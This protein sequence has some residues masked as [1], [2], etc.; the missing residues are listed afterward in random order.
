MKEWT[1]D[2]CGRPLKKKNRMHGYT[3]C[4]KHMHQLYNHG[5]FLDDNPRTTKDL[6]D[7][8]VVDGETVRMHLYN[9]RCERVASTL[10]DLDM[11]EDLKYKKWRLSHRHVVTGSGAG[12]IREMSHVIL[13]IPKE[14]DSNVVVDHI[15]GDALDNRRRNLR[16]CSQ[17][18]NSLNKRSMSNNALNVIGVTYDKA[19]NAYASEIRLR[20]IRWHLPRQKRFAD[21]VWQ[22]VVAEDIL[23]GEY[24][25][26]D[27]RARSLAICA[28]IDEARKEELRE[29]VTRK[30]FD[31]C[32]DMAFG[33]KLR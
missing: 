16:I 11:L 1:C 31:K 17:A 26:P 4:S 6:N 10:I 14:D 20:G 2:V 27:A 18:E 25:N 7:Y 32:P 23:F 28:D 21:A 33:H 30:L 5:R 9:Q 15:S 29:T 22:R 8:E 3:L 13:G 12:N 19:R 24:V